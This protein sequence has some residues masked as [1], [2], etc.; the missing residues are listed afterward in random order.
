[1]PKVSIVL[2]TYNGEKYINES[3]E[4]II[5][6]TFTDWELIIVNDYSTD[7]TPQIVHEYERKD[8]RIK[9]ID[10]LNNKKLPA[11]L[12]IGFKNAEGE[13]LTWTSDDNIYL[14]YA[15][16]TMVDYLDAHPTEHM[17]CTGMNWIDKGGRFLWKHP[18]YSNDDMMLR[19]LVGASFLY[20]RHVI[21]EVGE[22]DPEMFLVEDYEYWLRILFKYG[23]IAYINE[24]LYLYRYHDKSLTETR[25]NDIHKQL[26][27]LRKKYVASIIRRVK[28]N[29]SILS[30]IYY[31][32]KFNNELD[33][34]LDQ[35]FKEHVPI[36]R[37]DIKYSGNNVVVYGAGAFGEIAY[38]RMKDNIYCFADMDEEKVGEM[39]G[40]K[41]IVSLTTMKELSKIHHIVVAADIQN[42]YSFLITLDKLDIKTC[43]V[44]IPD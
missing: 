40:G 30:E 8:S 13:Y 24:V 10:N 25:K 6:Q 26:L 32:F 27:R 16:E 1:M 15:I 9:V 7:C 33:G 18:K 28:G 44:F 11:S 42:I 37:K 23:N 5:K 35:I 41:K 21:E 29:Y 4:S 19:D 39:I 17:V 34:E 14:P 3:V 20:R 31:D 43:S 38:E 12:N 22:Y 2:P 36:L